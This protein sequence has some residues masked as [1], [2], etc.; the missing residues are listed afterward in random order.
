MSEQTGTISRP[1]LGEAG[2]G[3][4]GEWLV[5]VFNNDHNTIAEVIEILTEATG[6]SEAEAK[7]ETWEIHHLGKSIVHYGEREECER[8]AAVISTIGIQVSVDRL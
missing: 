5:I 7:M 4:A 8:A 3:T 1:E 6:C 2:P